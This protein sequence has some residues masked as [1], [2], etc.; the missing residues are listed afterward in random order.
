MKDSLRLQKGHIDAHLAS[1]IL[2][3]GRPV[4]RDIEAAHVFMKVKVKHDQ[5]TVRAFVGKA[6]LKDE[7][8]GERKPGL[9]GANPGTAAAI[10]R[11]EACRRDRPKA[12][13]LG[14]HHD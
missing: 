4:T 1:L 10:F 3:P 5:L 9:K 8:G 7:A 12:R 11:G 6:K 2:F 14:R 13:S